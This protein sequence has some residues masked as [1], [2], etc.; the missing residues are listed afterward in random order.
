[1]VTK[2]ARHKNQVSSSASN[3]P[4]TTAKTTALARGCT[5]A[6]HQQ[7]HPKQH[8]LA[9]YNHHLG[10]WSRRSDIQTSTMHTPAKSRDVPPKWPKLTPHKHED[11]FQSRHA[12]FHTGFGATHS[13]ARRRCHPSSNVW[14]SIFHCTTIVCSINWKLKFDGRRW[15]KI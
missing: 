14:I 12:G 2:N 1:M 13:V 11:T 3:A 15:G 4:T 9:P 8:K 7:I 10:F 5:L 6:S